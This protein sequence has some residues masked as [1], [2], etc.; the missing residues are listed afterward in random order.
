MSV[1]KLMGLMVAFVA[2]G[3]LAFLGINW[4]DTIPAPANTSSDEYQQYTNLT[5]TVEI[6][7]VGV[8][9]IILF[10]ILTLI[11]VTLIILI[12]AVKIW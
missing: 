10:L 6:S 4:F 11:I 7:Y 2:I 12:K 8:E 3:M 9:G 1:A 5:D